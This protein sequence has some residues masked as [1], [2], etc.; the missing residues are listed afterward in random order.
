MT[1][2]ISEASAPP[3]NDVES[4]DPRRLKSPSVPVALAVVRILLG[5]VFLWA[6]LDK[7]FGLGFATP[8]E[9]ARVAG[10][11]PTSGFLAN[12]DGS[13]AEVFRA[14]AGQ[15]WVD[16]AFMLG[17]L[18]IGTALILGVAM[19]L[20]ALGATMLMGSLWLASIPLEN[21]PVIDEHILYASTAIALAASGAG[22]TFGLGR[23]WSSLPITRGQRWLA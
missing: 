8:R 7:T 12:V 22:N 18:L 14:M 6:F 1:V 20:A 17:M 13:L 19:N 2:E 3:L 16:W 15:P 11:S 10:G 5:L 23:A 4:N 9:K 21:N